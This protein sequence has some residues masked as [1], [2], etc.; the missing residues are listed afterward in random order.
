MC[1][2]VKVIFK[3]K[4]KQKGKCPRLLNA[5]MLSLLKDWLKD[6]TDICRKLILTSFGFTLN[7]CKFQ[8]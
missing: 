1:S 4:S 8:V 3:Y 2:D 7:I 5:S 6:S